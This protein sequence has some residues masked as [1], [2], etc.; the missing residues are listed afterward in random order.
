MV[1]IETVLNLSP[2]SRY[3]LH[4][5]TTPVVMAASKSFPDFEKKC[6]D[7]QFR[8]L[9]VSIHGSRS[10]RSSVT[11]PLIVAAKSITVPLPYETACPLGERKVTFSVID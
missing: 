4:K 11:T 1:S 2:I 10:W 7:M 3:R 9:A 5:P 6:A 8:L